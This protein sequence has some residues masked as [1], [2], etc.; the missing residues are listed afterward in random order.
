MSHGPLSAYSFDS[1]MSC[2]RQRT[3]DISNSEY[4]PSHGEESPEGPGPG[5]GSMSP[6]RA[7]RSRGLI[8]DCTM[9]VIGWVGQQVG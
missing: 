2:H 7:R 1:G 6:A 9:V 5:L 4:K 8:V 3:G